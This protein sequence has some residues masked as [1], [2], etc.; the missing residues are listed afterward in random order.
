RVLSYDAFFRMPQ[1]QQAEHVWKHL[2]VERTPIS[3]AC[4]GVVTTL[5]KLG[6]DPNTPDLASIRRYFQQQDASAFIDRVMQAANVA[7][8]TMTNNPFDPNERDR[9][10]RDPSVGKDPRFA[11]VLRI[12]PMVVDWPAAAREMSAQGYRCGLESDAM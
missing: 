10:L 3:E 9:W 2:F 7:S 1:P 11:A 4:R 8:I 6:I 5:T 12:D